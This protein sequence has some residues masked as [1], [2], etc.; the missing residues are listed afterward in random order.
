MLT[1]CDFDIFHFQKQTQVELLSNIGCKMF[2]FCVYPR[3]RLLLI[4]ITDR[5]FVNLPN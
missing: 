3:N 4:K 5:I 1:D 2:L